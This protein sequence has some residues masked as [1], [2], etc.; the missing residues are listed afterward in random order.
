MFRKMQNFLGGRVR[1]IVFGSAPV[2]NVVKEFVQVAFGCKV[3]CS[4][5]KF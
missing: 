5:S 1:S 3:S 2:S 4:A